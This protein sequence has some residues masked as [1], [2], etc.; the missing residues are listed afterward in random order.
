MDS[1]QVFTIGQQGLYMLLLVSAPLLLSVLVVGLV[2]SVFQAATQ[3]NEATLSF[4]PKVVVA[5]LVLATAGPWMLTMLVDYIQ[6]T[7]QSIPTA[8]G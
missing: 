4:V 7:L 8:V 1:Q 6:Q 3:I 2:V 5:V